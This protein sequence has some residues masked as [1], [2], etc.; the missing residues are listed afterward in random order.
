M[1]SRIYL[2]SLFSLS[3][4]TAALTLNISQGENSAVQAQLPLNVVEQPLAVK[5]ATISQVH[6]ISSKEKL[7]TLLAKISYFSAD[8]SQQV[9]DEEGGVLQQGQGH[10]L[11]RKPN[12]VRWQTTAPDENL[13]VSDGNT[14]WLFDPFID[15]VKAYTVDTSI[16][17]TPILLLSSNDKTLWENYTVTQANDKTFLIHAKDINS[18]V[19]TLELNFSYGLDDNKQ[20]LA[21]TAFSLLDST[22]QLS[23]VKLSNYQ[24]DSKPELSQFTFTLP[25][26]V[27]LYDQR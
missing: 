1:F 2:I 14:L 3:L 4:P 10:L 24:S 6:A 25:E 7:M 21:L 19:K 17:N 13:M 18:R 11:V 15:E 16:A 26:G 12:L 20:E 22:G 23:V 5:E 8:F 27:D 9:I